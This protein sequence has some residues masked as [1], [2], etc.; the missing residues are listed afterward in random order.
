V[1]VVSA[2]HKTEAALGL[3]NNKLFDLFNWIETASGQVEAER[4]PV[5]VR[6]HVKSAPRCFLSA[7]FPMDMWSV[8]CMLYKLFTGKIPPLRHTSTTRLTCLP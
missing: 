6:M 8:T 5:G 1:L 2:R 7:D 3:V 4:L